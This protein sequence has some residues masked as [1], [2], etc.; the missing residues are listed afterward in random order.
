MRGRF[1]A[2]DPI[3]PESPTW[4]LVELVRAA[5]ERAT[6]APC[7]DYRLARL[8]GLAPSTV[9]GW[10]AGK[11]MAAG[12][13][14]RAA[15]LAGV[16]PAPWLLEI[17]AER[18]P[19][20]GARQ[21]FERAAARLAGTAAAVML[22]AAVLLAPGPAVA[23]TRAAVAGY[24]IEPVIYYTPIGRSDPARGRPGH[25][26]GNEAPSRREAARRVPKPASIP[27]VTTCT[28]ASPCPSHSLH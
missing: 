2:D 25:G 28:G 11:R 7:T 5:H 22:A 16:D 26:A 27:G 9:T 18:E 14:V 3:A 15:E 23:A 6:G 17:T 12:A 24:V 13:V 8:L 4:R 1:P 20:P 21:V 19:D 10:R